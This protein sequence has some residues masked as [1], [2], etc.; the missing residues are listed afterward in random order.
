MRLGH[1]DHQH[2]VLDT[3]P[4]VTKLPNT[5]HHLETS[6]TNF[7]ASFFLLGMAAKTGADQRPTEN[8]K[9]DP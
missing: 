5:G 8:N 1:L 7:V 9:A 3:L 2:E 6:P 4:L